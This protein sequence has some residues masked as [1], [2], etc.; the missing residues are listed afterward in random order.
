MIDFNTCCMKIYKMLLAHICL[1]R[2]LLKAF[3]YPHVQLQPS[4]GAMPL[5]VAFVIDAK[6]CNTR[7]CSKNAAQWRE[8][9]LVLLDVNA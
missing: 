3:A 6:M 8:V 7:P 5:W 9:S 4:L 1:Q 2:N